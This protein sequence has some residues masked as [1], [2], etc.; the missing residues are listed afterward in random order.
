MLFRAII[1]LSPWLYHIQERVKPVPGA[2]FVQP[3]ARRRHALNVA[4]ALQRAQ[5]RTQRGAERNAPDVSKARQRVPQSVGG[6]LLDAD[7]ATVLLR[8]DTDRTGG[9]P[10]V[11]AP[12]VKEV[13]QPQPVKVLDI[14]A[15]REL[16]EIEIGAQQMHGEVR[17]QRELEVASVP[18]EGRRRHARIRRGRVESAVAEEHLHRDHVREDERRR[19]VDG[20]QALRRAGSCMGETR[21]SWGTGQDIG[22]TYMS[23]HASS[24]GM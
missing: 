23:L 13:V 1:K 18:E 14:V 17:A 5:A 16:G 4:F 21:L 7:E 9:D 6:E 19:L 20:L 2:P 8:A 11:D 12:E 24:M 15:A 22:T 10:N 3:R